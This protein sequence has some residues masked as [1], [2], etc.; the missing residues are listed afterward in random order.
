[1]SRILHTEAAILRKCKLFLYFL[2]VTLGV[3]GNTGTSSAFEFYHRVLN[4]SHIL[5]LIYLQKSF[6]TL[7]ENACFV[8]PENFLEPLIGIEPMTPTL[9]WWCST[10]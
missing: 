8:N 4:L 7:P 9:P 2:L 6:F 10:S 5:A 3:M 1:M